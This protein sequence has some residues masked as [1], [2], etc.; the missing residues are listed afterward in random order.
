MNKILATIFTSSLL[1]F[2]FSQTKSELVQQRIEMLSENLESEELDLTNVIDQLNYYFDHPL[3]L[4]SATE[5]QLGSLGLL[6]EIQINNLL[7]HR[8][9]FGKLISIYELQSLRYW[10]L[11][12]IRNVLPFVQVDDRLTQVHVGLKEAL[13]QGKFEAYLRFQSTLSPKKAYEKVPDSILESSNSY[14]HGDKNRYYTRLRFSYRTNISVGV[15]GEKDPG[16]AFFKGAQKQG[17]DF[18]SAHAFYS[19]GKYI[20]S[21]AVGDYQIQ[22]GQGLNLWSGYAFGKTA[23]VSNVKKNAQTLRPYTSVDE[24]RFMRGAAIDLAY[25]NIELTAFASRKMV[26]A[27]VIE[28]SS[29]NELQ[30]VSS[31][32]L[33]GFHRTNSEIQKRKSLEE[34]ILGTNLRYRKGGFQMGTA[35]VYQHYSR[36][37]SKELKPYNQ[38]DFR[39]KNLPSASFDYSYVWRNVNLFGEIS[40]SFFSKKQAVLQGLIIALDAKATLSFL[41]RNYNRAYQTFYNN[42]FSEGSTTQ[43]ESGF[44]SGLSLKLS[45]AWNLNTYFDVFQQA[46]LKYL[47]DAPGRGNE[48]LAQLNYKPSKKLEVYARFRQQVRS[49]NSRDLDETIT[50]IE[51]VTQ[52]NYRINLSFKAS[53]SLLFKSRIEYV[54]LNRLSNTPEQGM[55]MTQDLVFKPKSFPLDIAL[56]YALFDTDSYDSRLYSYE[57]NA[58]Y[59]FS[60]PAY[61]YQG[62]RAYVL[63]RYTFFRKFDLWIRYGT[64]LYANRT[65]L[66]TGAEEISGNQKSELTVQFRM[67]F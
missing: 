11:E 24:N 13:K 36:N 12:T 29:V 23:D 15:T 52:R 47:V 8:K 56:R 54:T 50:E 39:A 28:D 63:I 35:F 14:Y 64:F 62:S 55:L 7:L 31:I 1:F 40:H 18:Y 4:N 21:I 66:G 30:Y 32:N 17:F 2:S 49:K 33:T 61:Y 10:D 22:I 67:Q 3:N 9:Q 51:Q 34:T 65:S 38:F 5:E 41:Y 58:L 60:I 25:K 27:T 20:K 46:W 59:V 16:E 19:G 26:D 53:E 44:Y 43:N 6:T 37:Y 42:G 48:F 45:K 57:A